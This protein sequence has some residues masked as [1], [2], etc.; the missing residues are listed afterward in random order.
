MAL[1]AYQFQNAPQVRLFGPVGLYVGIVFLCATIRLGYKKH[2]HP[3][4]ACVLFALF[5]GVLAVSCLWTPNQNYG[6]NKACCFFLY[7]WPLF[8]AAYRIIASSPERRHRLLWWIVLFSSGIILVILDIFSQHLDRMPLIL[9]A[10]YLVTG[11]TLGAGFAC[12]L[13][14]SFYAYLRT[15]FS[16]ERLVRRQALLFFWSVTCF[17]GVSSYVQLNLG[18]RGPVIAAG[19]VFLAFYGGNIGQEHAQK[20]ENH[21]LVYLKHAVLVMGVCTLMYFLL[22]WLFQTGVS[23]FLDRCRAV[24]SPQGDMSIQLR[25]MYIVSAFEAFLAHPLFGLGAGGWPVFNGDGQVFWYPHNMVLEVASETGILG[26]G[27]LTSFLISLARLLP[28]RDFYRNAHAAVFCLLL[29]FSGFNALKSGDINDN[30]LF[31]VALG[32]AAGMGRFSSQG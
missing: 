4:G 14:R 19:I 9:G 17:M 30:T 5:G 12:L 27:V 18:G 21:T 7:T 10:N 11:Q 2:H 28:V 22:A 29:L 24:L 15:H 20:A 32:L 13:V 31:F 25:L 26:V 16:H 1:F 23:P 6:F 3:D 8:F